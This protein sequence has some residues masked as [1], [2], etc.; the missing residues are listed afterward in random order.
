MFSLLGKGRPLTGR[1]FSM[2]GKAGGV[3]GGWFGVGRDSL[4]MGGVRDCVRGMGCKEGVCRGRGPQGRPPQ[5]GAWG[6]RRSPRGSGRRPERPAGPSSAG[7]CG[8][9]GDG[10]ADRGR[11]RR[12]GGGR[13]PPPAPAAGR[14]VRRTVPT[15]AARR[16]RRSRNG[17]RPALSPLGKAPPM[18]YNRGRTQGKR[19]AAP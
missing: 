17:L 18:R 13:R 5:A 7:I 16:F 3:F 14:T 8:G 12:G 6:G 2:R 1:S 4:R 10:F 19:G 9:E 15:G 11:G